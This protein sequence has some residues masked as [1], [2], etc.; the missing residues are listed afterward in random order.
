[1][2]RPAPRFTTCWRMRWGLRGF[3]VRHRRGGCDEELGLGQ[4]E[5][6]SVDVQG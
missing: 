6:I 3:E 1:M 4:R 5:R 2:S